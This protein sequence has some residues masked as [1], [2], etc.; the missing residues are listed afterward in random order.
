[1]Q[2]SKIVLFIV[3]LFCF[4]GFILVARQ[5]QEEVEN[6]KSVNEKV[7][8]TEKVVEKKVESKKKSGYQGEDFK[9]PNMTFFDNV[10]SL[11]K[12]E[13]I[14]DIIVILT[15][16][17][18]VL[19]QGQQKTLLDRDAS[20]DALVKTFEK[21]AAQI[22]EQSKYILPLLDESLEVSK[23][24]KLGITLIDEKSLVHAYAISTDKPSVF[25][26]AIIKTDEQ[27]LQFAAELFI[28]LKDFKRGLRKTRGV[29]KRELELKKQV[30]EEDVNKKPQ[31]LGEKEP[32]YAV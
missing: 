16:A 13:T 25:F 14:E 21:F 17:E 9:H 15:A 5:A 7:E 29:Y 3:T 30:K 19:R 26:K 18:D 2:I 8:I 32:L 12:P 6:L 31:E 24:K 22:Q 1:M 20:R 27:L 10:I 28:F 4:F 23:L 11:T